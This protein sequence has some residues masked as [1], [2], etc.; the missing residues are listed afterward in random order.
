MRVPI[1]LELN[2]DIFLIAITLNILFKNNPIFL[3]LC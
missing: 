2:V 1:P 3:T